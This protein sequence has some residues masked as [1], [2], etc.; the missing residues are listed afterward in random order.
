MPAATQQ[1]RSP[2]VVAAMSA[3]AGGWRPA[4]PLVRISRLVAAAASSR[5]RPSMKI[6]GPS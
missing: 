5:I 2:D 1:P 6:A 4:P 3:I